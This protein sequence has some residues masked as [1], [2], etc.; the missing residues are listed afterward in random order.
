[1]FHSLI[2]NIGHLSIILS[3]VSSLLAA[4][5]YFNASNA[6]IEKEKSWLN[7]SR[8]VFYVHCLSVFGIVAS[9]FGIIYNH[10]YEYY[11]AWSHSS[12]NLPTHFMI[13]CFWE[14]QEGSFLLWMFWHSILGIILMNTQRE[15]EAPMMSVFALV[16]AFLASMILGIVFFDVKLGSSPF[17]LLRDFMTDAPVFKL[18]P[19]FVPKDGTGL[20]PLLQNYWM[21]IHPPTLFLGF[22]TTLIPFS[23]CIAG[24]WKGKYKEWIRPALP[25]A[26]FSALVLGIGILMGG[27]W[28]Y[29][30]LNFG[31]YWNWDPV[32]NAVYVP[33]LILVASIHSM[34]VFNKNNTALKT[35]IIMVITSFLLILYST[36]L[37]RSGILGN[38]SVHSFTDLGLS[39]QLLVYLLA[40]VA[41]SIYLVARSWKHIPSDKHEASVWSREFWVFMG[42][43]TLCLA[44]FQII[45]TTSIPVYNAISNGLGI[46]SSLALPAD[47]VEHYSKFQVWFS[48]LIALFSGTGQF[49]YWK[50]M[51]KEK[52]QKAIYTPLV[53]TL[54]TV[55]AII[56]FTKISNISYIVL[57]TTAVYSLVSNISIFTSLIKQNPSLS[58]GAVAHMGIAM[59]LIGVLYSAGYS[60]IISNNTSG[61]LY[62]KEFTTQ[63]NQDNVLLFRNDKIKMGDYNVSYKGPRI[64]ADGMPGY[65]NK[66]QIRVIEDKYKAILYKDAVWKDKVYFK[67]GDTIH[68]MPENTF[69]EMEFTKADGVGFT[70]YPRA[71][72]NKE[73]G[74][75][76]SPDIKKMWG[77]DLYSHV[78]SIP[79][80]NEE[81]DWSPLELKD[82][83]IGDTFLV[84]DYYAIFENVERVSE[85]EEIPLS[86]S[87][88]AVKAHI[89]ILGKNQDVYMEPIFVIH[90]QMIG[91]VSD[92]NLG[93]GIRLTLM[94][95]DP[96]SG[97][98]TLGMNTTQKDWVILK[99]ME[100]PLIDLLW[101]GSFMVMFGFIIAI[102]RRYS[103]FKRE[104]P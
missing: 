57:L 27:Y 56:G 46:K 33:W 96:K 14:G 61:L 18:Q 39:G 102:R 73:M 19:E 24:L 28:A 101:G 63:M 29:E 103:E 69:Y 30:T 26:H 82:L 75:L 36:F 35:A 93:L 5:G 16:Q 80:P 85:V 74:L 52:L 65:I 58:G 99:A 95:I 86:E 87:D 76:A 40:F 88:A 51:D 32:E 49:F 104:Q 59:M 64:E 72:V 98:F 78:S 4:Y 48:A 10:Y 91:R 70:L 84:N 11:Y 6:T 60:K 15:W 67:K 9:L 53:V 55:S 43:T 21:V 25:W 3:F 100:K 20:N 2:G 97:K 68:Y 38:A 13:S 62:S 8:I 83:S 44:A 1:V 17:I 41:L 94:N 23:F 71:Q 90:N 89:K 77:K 54:L 47:Q 42:V 79:D 12:N 7:F 31:G 50:K 45:A 92:D 81:K 66:E 22:A 34:I 37:T